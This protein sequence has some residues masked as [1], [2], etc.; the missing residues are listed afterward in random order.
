[1]VYLET[2]TTLTAVPGILV[3]HAT[4][5]AHLT[6]CTV[7]L[8]PQ[9][10]TA[11]VCIRGGAAGS[12][13]TDALRPGTL[14]PSVH[15]LLL[16]GGSAF[17]LDAATGVM[18]Y[19]VAQGIG[20]E[21]R[22]ARIPIVPAAVIYDLGLG[23]AAVR[24]TAEDGYAAAQ[25]ATAGPVTEGCIGA[26]CGATAGKALGM[27]RAV[28]SGLGSW[29]A[30]AADGTR[31]AALAV[32]NAFG[33]VTDPA[34]GRVLAGHRHH[35]GS[36]FAPTVEAMQGPA[37]SPHATHLEN[38]TLVV[39]ATD[40]T[41]TK[42]HANALANMADD[43]I[44]RCVRPAHTQMDGDAVFALATGRRQTSLSLS[45]LGALAADCVAQAIVRA[46]LQATA[47]GGLP[48]ARDLESWA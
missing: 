4:L 7:I 16:A 37:T 11:G 42:E 41:L 8:C 24:P 26:G 27:D 46:I 25:S 3:G 44:A 43:G 34:T 33:E 17:G 14:T 39:V 47:A 1:M 15:G 22:H 31:V 38:T 32:V 19:L 6:G 40:A 12:R 48:A 5:D 28:K 21:T 2:N 35:T 10:A 13:E 23:D 45:A 36:G 20:F 9:G 30:T 29:A 18:R